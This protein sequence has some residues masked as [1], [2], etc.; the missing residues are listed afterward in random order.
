MDTTNYNRRGVAIRRARVKPYIVRGSSRST[1]S[2]PL[3]SPPLPILYCYYPKSGWTKCRPACDVFTE[4]TGYEM[5]FSSSSLYYSRVCWLYLAKWEN[6]FLVTV[7]QKWYYEEKRELTSNANVK[8]CQFVRA[9]NWLGFNFKLAIFFPI[10]CIERRSDFRGQWQQL[11]W[12]DSYIFS[13]HIC[14]CLN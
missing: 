14:C 5:Q 4:S 8:F 10:I 9:L 13:P 1:L 11:P 12:Y 2:R 3:E 7:S 6:M